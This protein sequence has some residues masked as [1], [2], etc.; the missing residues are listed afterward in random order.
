MC[1]FLG[2]CKLKLKAWDSAAA[3]A[4]AFAIGK[5]ESAAIH[6]LQSKVQ[7][8]VVRAL[9]EVVRVRGMRGFLQHETVAKD[10]FN[11]GF[12][13][14]VASLDVWCNQ[15]M[16]KDDNQLV[17]GTS[18][19]LFCFGWLRW[20]GGLVVKADSTER[21]HTCKIFPLPFPRA[22]VRKNDCRIKVQPSKGKLFRIAKGC[23]LKF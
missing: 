5:F 12:T 9:K 20:F 6:N 3:I 14:G 7:A 4:R 15:L 19:C 1:I 21:L 10:L 11:R 18:R 13:S 16:N 23:R 2:N 22:M 8:D 17:P